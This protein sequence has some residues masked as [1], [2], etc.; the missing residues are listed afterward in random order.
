M[1]VGTCGYFALVDFPDRAA[2]TSWRFLTEDECNFVIE[3][4]RKD[5]DDVQAEPFNLRRWAAAGLDLKV[6]GFAL[7]FFC[8]STIVYA[9]AYFLPI[10]LRQNVSIDRSKHHMPC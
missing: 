6:W 10:I 5:R 2:R 8:L 1:L 9:T 3:R 7:I 4:V